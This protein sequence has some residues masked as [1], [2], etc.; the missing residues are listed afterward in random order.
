MKI[1]QDKELQAFAFDIFK[2]KELTVDEAYNKA[3]LFLDEKRNKDNLKIIPSDSIK[4]KAK[5]RIDY[6]RNVVVDF[7]YFKDNEF[8]LDDLRFVFLSNEDQNIKKVVE[9]VIDEV[10]KQL[11]IKGC[12]TGS[13]EAVLQHSW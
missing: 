5:T 2:H 7:N 9:Y 10:N 4:I 6:S 12:I 11:K 1:E 13:V 3:K 8:L